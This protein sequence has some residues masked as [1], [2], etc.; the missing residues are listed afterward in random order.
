[1]YSQCNVVT[2]KMIT[3]IQMIEGTPVIAML[4]MAKHITLITEDL[5]TI[6]TG[7]IVLVARWLHSIDIKI[8]VH[9]IEKMVMITGD[10]QTLRTI[11]LNKTY[12]MNGANELLIQLFLWGLS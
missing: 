3:K 8:K 5:M 11:G 2:H 12:L 1:M 9:R 4:R 10:L 7:I 6:P